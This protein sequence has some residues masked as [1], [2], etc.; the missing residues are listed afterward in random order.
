MKSNKLKI[1]HLISGLDRGGI[2]RWLLGVLPH[3]DLKRHSVDFLSRL[4]TESALDRQFID[5]GA[6]VYL[7]AGNRFNFSSY[8]DQLAHLI[9][10]EKYDIIHNHLAHHGGIPARIY[11]RLGVPSVVSFHNAKLGALQFGNPIKRWISSAYSKRGL[12]YMI[13][14]CHIVTGCSEDV[15][16]ELGQVIS[17]E[18]SETRVLHYGVDIP[19]RLLPQEIEEVKCSIGVALDKKIVVHVGSFTP[20]KNHYVLL[21]IAQQV[22]EKRSDVVFVFV[23]DGKLRAN[24]E[25]YAMELGLLDSVRFLGLRKDVERILSSAEVFLFPSLFEGL[26]VACLEA[27]AAG[28]PVVGSNVPGTKLLVINDLTGFLC[29]KDD[30][31]AFTRKIHLLLD[32]QELR[33]DIG[34]QARDFVRR[35]FSYD[36]SAAHLMEIYQ[37]LF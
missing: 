3:L 21:E 10:V 8:C 30:T 22:L 31:H 2:E 34:E 24:V 25:R 37:T 19:E 16:S 18:D 29:E 12:N 32:D 5:L 35:E 36:A 6:R 4:P 1:L 9:R 17:L 23:G 28:L 14:K 27:L 26:P 13:K 7:N 33:N 15:L 11:S 20:Q